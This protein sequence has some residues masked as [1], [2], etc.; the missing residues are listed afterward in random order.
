MK[1]KIKFL[2]L[3][4]DGTLTDGKIYM[5]DSGEIMKAFNIKDGYSIKEILPELKIIPIV[6]TGRKS[7]IVEKRCKELEIKEVYQGCGKK[8]EQLQ[9]ILQEYSVKNKECYTFSNCAYCGDDLIDFEC[10][11]EIKQAGG[12]IGCPQDAVTSIR[13]ISDFIST[14]SGGEGAV[15]EFVDF[16]KNDII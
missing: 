1:K 15:R 12:V 6:I 16:L 10:M 9:N 8:R 13:E 5:G 7:K 3:D 2:V 14:K 11:Q 4:V